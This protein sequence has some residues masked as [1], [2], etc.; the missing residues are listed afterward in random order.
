[1]TVNAELIDGENAQHLWH[2]QYE[3]DIRDVLALQRELAVAVTRE[4]VGDKAVPAESR[5]AERNRSVNPQAY[6]AYLKAEYFSGK[7][8]PDGYAKADAYYLKSI[9]LDPRFAPAYAGRAEM[10]AFEAYT[11][12]LPPLPTWALAESL[13]AQALALDPES[14]LAHTMKGMIALTPHCDRATAERELNR[15]LALSPGDIGVL[16]YHSWYLM[17]TGRTNE[18]VMEKKRVLDADPVSVNTGSEYGM[19]LS[20]AGR[21]DEAIEQ[22]SQMLELDPQFAPTLTRLGVAYASEGKYEQA[23]EEFGK[24]V[25]IDENPT[26]L[27]NMGY[28]Y[29]RW[30]RPQDALAV[31]QRMTELSAH[32]F[33][34]PS[35]IARIYATL[36]DRDRA[37]AWLAKA[38]IG[39]RP[40]VNDAGFDGLRADAGFRAIEAKLRPSA[41]CALM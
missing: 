26:A 6:E 21:Q 25:A 9:G 12:R 30:G 28:A 8:M 3:R 40:F 27:G 11:N 18:A 19:Y 10:L 22:L 2:A 38:G 32:R 36:G 33:V 31:V 29:A 34:S 24:S 17:Q 13:L 16:T 1:M 37:L 20:L 14:S 5:L 4:A 39:D 35:M 7:Q 41:E 23:I 15:A